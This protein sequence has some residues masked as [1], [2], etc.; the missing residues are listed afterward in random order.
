MPIDAVM[1]LTGLGRAKIYNIVRAGEF[2]KHCKPGG[3][4]SRWSE[5][6]VKAW[7]DEVIRRRD[8]R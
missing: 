7:R 4:A 2:P 6:E 8:A 1:Q 3:S 5:N